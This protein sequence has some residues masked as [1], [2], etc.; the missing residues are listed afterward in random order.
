V[1]TEGVGLDRRT[2]P[3]F[4]VSCPVNFSVDLLGSQFLVERFSS[5]GTVLDISRNGLLADVDRL[6]AV[7]T[8][9]VLS[10]VNAQ[11]LVWPHKV[12]GQVRRSAMGNAGWKIG[13]EFDALVDILPQAAHAGVV[14]EV[15]TA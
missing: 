11:G 12:R 2:Y 1:S 9:C 8:D 14:P 7:G 10:L 6:V 4:S 15:R 3:R 5:S 13:I